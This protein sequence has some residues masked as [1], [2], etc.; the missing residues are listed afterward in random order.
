M[1]DVNVARA[2]TAP[3]HGSNL[4]GPDVAAFDQKIF[5]MHDQH[6]LHRGLT[7]H[8]KIPKKTAPEAVSK[9]KA[10]LHQRMGP[11]VGQGGSQQSFRTG[12]QNKSRGNIFSAAATT[13][14]NDK[15]DPIRRAKFV[16]KKKAGSSAGSRQWRSVGGGSP[17]WFALQWQT[18]L[19][20]CRLS[21]ILRSGVI[22]HWES[23]QPPITRTPIPFPTRNKKQEGCGQ[24]TGEGGH[25]A[26]PQEPLPGLLQQ[27]VS[28]SQ[29]NRGFTFSYKPVHS[30]QTSGGSTLSDG[31]GSVSQSIHPSS[32]VDS[33]YGH[34]IFTFQWAIPWGSFS[35]FML[36]NGATNS[37]LPFGLATSPREFTKLLPPVVQL[38]RMQGVRLHVYLDDWLI[39]ADSPEMASSHA[40]LVMRVLRHL[41]WIIRFEISKLTWKQEFDF[42]GIHFRKGV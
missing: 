4:V 39:L 36:T 26:R 25:K 10:S 7:S 12:Q 1:E 23:H 29:E 41:G 37:H 21:K 17:D 27:A 3:F 31:N 30:E 28:Y 9:T 35:D 11:P 24:S 13:G 20:E 38:L 32:R 34:P 33:V 6:A 16:F 5:S 42:I 14:N 15:H 8:F 22:L 18:L 19:G 40:Q 2:R